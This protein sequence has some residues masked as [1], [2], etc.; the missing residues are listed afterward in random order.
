[1][2]R[3]TNL[4]RRARAAPILAARRD[5]L[6]SLAALARLPLGRVDEVLAIVGLEGRK[7]RCLIGP[8]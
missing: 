3:S 6:R 4:A 1:M 2:G 5:H 8:R 7:S